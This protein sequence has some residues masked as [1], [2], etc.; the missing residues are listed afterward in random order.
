[1]NQFEAAKIKRF[2][3]RSIALFFTF[4]ESLRIAQFGQR[5]EVSN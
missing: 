1:M 3:F 2:Y 4:A 5:K